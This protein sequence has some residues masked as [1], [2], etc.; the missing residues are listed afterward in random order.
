MEYRHHLWRGSGLNLNTLT[1]GTSGTGLSGSTTYN[2]SGA[3]TFTVTSNATN[4]N[5]GSTIVARDGS[6]NFSAG[7]ITA[8][9]NGN[10]S[11]AT[12]ATTATTASNATTA[13][14]LAVN[15]SGVNNVAN[16]I[17]RTDGSGYIQAGW[18]NSVSGDNGRAT[19]SRVRSVRRCLSAVLHRCQLQ[20]GNGAYSIQPRVQRR[21]HGRWEHLLH[22]HWRWSDHNVR[23]NW[24]Q[25]RARGQDHH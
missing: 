1:L 24:C 2:G 25:Y 12:T 20:C 7:T 15:S 6:G 5:T 19:I 4:A 21:N 8:A 14:G 10:A 3:A 13:G 17:V 18:I 16:Q 11:T 9:L 22:L 23:S